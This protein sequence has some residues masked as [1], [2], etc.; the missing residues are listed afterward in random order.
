MFTN[1]W[2]WAALVL[3]IAC[4][5][6]IRQ[7]FASKHANSVE[8]KIKNWLEEAKTQAKEVVFE[9][10]ERA[11]KLLEEVKNEEKSRKVQLDKLQ[12]R[13]LN[14]EEALEKNLAEIT[15]KKGGLDEESK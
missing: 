14:K 15:L 7:V 8:Q 4:G 2:L 3:G 9:A 1:P 12:E 13:L 10:K 5:Y 11:A 6:V